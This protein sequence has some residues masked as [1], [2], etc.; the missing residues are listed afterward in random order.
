MYASIFDIHSTIPK[1]RYFFDIIDALLASHESEMIH[2]EHILTKGGSK[3]KEKL[4][5]SELP[6][7]FTT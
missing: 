7:D 6:R 3:R 1:N 4:K 2:L 5:A